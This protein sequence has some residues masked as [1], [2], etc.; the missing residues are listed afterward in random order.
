MR[1]QL[2]YGKITYIS[3]LLIDILSL[4]LA[5]IIAGQIYLDG[6]AS[7]HYSFKD[8]QS[9]ILFMAIIDVFV[10]VIFNTLNRVLRRRK[11]KEIIEGTKHVGISFVLL[12]V[13]LFTTKQGAAY[14]RVTVYLAYGIY[15]VLFVGTHIVWKTILKLF[16]KKNDKETAVLM[17]TDRFVYEGLKE[18]EDE[19][20]DVK[21][22]FLLKNIE[23]EK[24]EGIPVARNI[25]EVISVICWKWI[26]KV[27]VYGLDHQMIPGELD[28]ASWEMGLSINTID[29]E[30]KVLQ[31]KTIANEDPKFGALSFLEGK[32]DIPFPIRRVYWITETEAAQHRGFHAHKLNCQLLFCPHGKIDIILDNGEEKTTVTLEGPGKGLLLMPGMWRE[33]VWQETGSVLCVLASEYY[34]PDEYIRD[35]E[36]FKAYKEKSKSKSTTDINLE[37]EKQKDEDSVCVVSPNGAGTESGTAVSV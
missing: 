25:N 31:L 1:E 24:I 33:M 29:F 18:L 8:Y 28:K 37:E 6:A 17:T 22:I 23:R 27:Y 16:R 15:F 20:I 21:S 14:S 32:R 2:Q 30:Y 3:F 35:Y 34:D 12:T 11:R 9:V 10:T 19:N 13:V 26:D 4:I 5:N 7:K 36:E